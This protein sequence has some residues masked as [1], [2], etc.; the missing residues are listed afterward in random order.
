MFMFSVQHNQKS[1]NRLSSGS[2]AADHLVVL[3]PTQRLKGEHEE[4]TVA[5]EKLQKNNRWFEVQFK[6]GGA[7]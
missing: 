5:I 6:K 3:Q 4:G 1:E 7:K 2:F